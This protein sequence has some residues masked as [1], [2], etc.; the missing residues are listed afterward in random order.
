MPQNAPTLSNGRYQLLDVLGTGGMAV[1]Y[2]V[3][4]TRLQAER[5]LKLLSSEMMASPRMR[6]RFLGEAR[7]MAALHHPNLVTVHDV[8][9]DRGQV[10]IVMEL[11]EGGTL[12][13]WVKD[14]GA[15]P[16][17]MAARVMIQVLEA[18]EEAHD[19]VVVHRDIKPHNVLLTTRGRPLLTDFGIARAA[20]TGVGTL[21]KTGVAIGTPGYMAPEQHKEA[22]SADGRADIFALGATLYAVLKAELPLG[23][24]ASEV[25]QQLYAELPAALAAIVRKATR[26]LPADR[27]QTAAEMRA[28][29]DDALAQLPEDPSD[30][31]ALGGKRTR[32]APVLVE[33]FHV[34]TMDA[35]TVASNADASSGGFPGSM[36]GGPLFKPQGTMLGNASRRWQ[37]LVALVVLALAVGGGVW[38]GGRPDAPA[39]AEAPPTVSAPATPA[40]AAPVQAPFEEAPPSDPEPLP[41]EDPGPSEQPAPAETEPSSPSPGTTQTPG[42]TTAPSTQ[43]AAEPQPAALA[44]DVPHPKVRVSVRSR[45]FARWQVSGD[46]SDAG[47]KDYFRD[48][49][50]APGTYRF[51]LETEDGR[52]HDFTLQLDGSKDKVSVCYDFEKGGPC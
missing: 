12:W 33:D 43:Q 42:T 46:T 16:P 23:I 31:P 37:M 45:P 25:E 49:M 29:L 40:A 20:D 52:S 27:Y 39:P 17:A 14:H 50:D 30:T 18:V 3:F 34:P 26:F 21:T 47:D 7:T 24:Y 5:A 6:A 13:D 38:W 35:A 28:A 32:S 10:F 15:M 4:D 36:T 19:R 44:P 11:V 8:G 2:R 48:R 9:E 41:I 22:K 1:V 51:H